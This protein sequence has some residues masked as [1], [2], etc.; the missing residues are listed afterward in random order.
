MFARQQIL[1]TLRKMGMSDTDIQGLQK[2]TA[3]ECW[4]EDMLV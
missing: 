4:G 3:A 1:K 2:S